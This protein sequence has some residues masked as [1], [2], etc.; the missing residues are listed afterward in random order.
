MIF[1]LGI[2]IGG[3]IAC[4]LNGIVGFLGA[5]RGLYQFKTPKNFSEELLILSFGWPVAVPWLIW[6]AYQL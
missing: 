3:V 5:R 4:L 2:Y 6:R 1:I